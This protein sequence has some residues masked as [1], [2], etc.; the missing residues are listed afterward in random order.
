MVF[1]LRALFFS[2]IVLPYCLYAIDLSL[3][4]KAYLKTLGTVKVCVD[5]D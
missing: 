5:P 2:F 1:T 3:E 4:E